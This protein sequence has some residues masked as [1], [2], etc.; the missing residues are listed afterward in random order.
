MKNKSLLRSFIN[1][2]NGLKLGLLHERNMKLH[3]L[4]AVLVIAAGLVLELD[5]MRWAVLV[6][7]VSAVIAAELFNTALENVVDMITS[8]FSQTAKLVKDTA[9]A[10]VLVVSIAA[11]II[12]ILVFYQPFMQFIEKHF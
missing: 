2:F 6:L 12:G 5:A 10:A 9:A 8:Q 4:A 1:A 3:L 7:T 11:A